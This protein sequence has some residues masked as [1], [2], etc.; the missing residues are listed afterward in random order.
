MPAKPIPW[1]ACGD[2]HGDMRDIPTL[3]AFWDF[4]SYF[5]P[6]IR[7]GL[8]DHF[9]FRYLRAK[10]SEGERYESG[11]MDFQCG[12]D[13]LRKYKPTHVCWGN[14]DD[15][16]WELTRHPNQNIADGAK[17]MV[18]EIEDAAKSAKVQ[19]PFSV[20]HCLTIGDLKIVHGFAH[21]RPAMVQ[22]AMLYGK[23]LQGDLHTDEHVPAPGLKGRCELWCVPCMCR[24]DMPYL[25]RSMGSLKH[26]HGWAYGHVHPDGTTTVHIATK[27]NGRWFLPTEFKEF[28]GKA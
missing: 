23:V 22:A 18:E 8:G 25:K 4:V 15:R 2:T 1:V 6:K 5:K 27:H 12:L 21:S 24:L 28:K 26:C 7:I 20:R 10:A 3:E 11:Q 19:V 14:H 13:F 17:R 9:D 16:V